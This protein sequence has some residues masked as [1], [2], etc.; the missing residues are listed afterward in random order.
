MHLCHG[1]DQQINRLWAAVMTLS[2]EGRLAADR[3]LLDTRIDGEVAESFQVRIEC[4]M[5]SGVRAE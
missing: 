3:R 1:G 2:G 5:V 4:S